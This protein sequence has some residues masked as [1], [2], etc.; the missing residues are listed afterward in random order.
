MPRKARQRSETGIYHIMMRGINK[1]EIFYNHKDKMKLFELMIR[2]KEI[3]HFKLYGYCFMDNHVHLLLK[4][5]I[6][7][8]PVVVKRISSSYVYW[9]NEQHERCGHLFQERYKSEPVEDD[10]YFLTVLRYIHQ[11]P[12]QAGLV[13]NFSD[14]RWSS[15]NEYMKGPIITDT[16]FALKIFSSEREKAVELFNAFTCE[17]NDDRCLDY[18]EKGKISDEEIREKLAHHNINDLKQL[19]ALDKQE[20][21][22]LIR[23]LKSIDGVTLRQ[24][25]RVTGISK[26]ALSRIQ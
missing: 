25:S 8:L 16:D 15:F 6:E 17:N 5:T 10:A 23:M 2:F 12:I 1:Q 21:V 18:D 24:L 4:E 9:F 20:L 13:N 26:S 22:R 11:N 19:L 3:S 7:P 14:Y